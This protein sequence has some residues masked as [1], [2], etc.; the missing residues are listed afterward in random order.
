MLI[1]N[2]AN[3]SV[4]V[5]SSTQR[6]MPIKNTLYSTSSKLTHNWLP[7]PNGLLLRIS[8][9]TLYFYTLS[10]KKEGHF[11]FRHNFAICWDCNFVQ[12]GLNCTLAD[13]NMGDLVQREH[14]ENW[15][16]IGMGPAVASTRV[17]SWRRWGVGR[18]CSP[19]HTEHPTLLGEESGRGNF[20]C[21]VISRWHILVNSEVLTA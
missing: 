2:E 16:G 9:C 10:P 6:R 1:L 14:P 19:A 4:S 11:N 17:Q 7:L 12:E 8:A 5:T 3:S 20:F 15:G 18:G 21:F 13:P